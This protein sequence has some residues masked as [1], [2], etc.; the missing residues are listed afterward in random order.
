MILQAKSITDYI[1]TIN[2]Y[3]ELEEPEDGKKLKP[4]L[5]INETDS[6]KIQGVI[7][8]I[9]RFNNFPSLTH[10][11]RKKPHIRK[12]NLLA[13][14]R[15]YDNKCV[16]KCKISDLCD[17]LEMKNSGRIMVISRFCNEMH[18]DKIIFVHRWMEL[19]YKTH[20]TTAWGINHYILQWILNPK[21]GKLR[22]H[23]PAKRLE[24][25]RQYMIWA[26][27]KKKY[28][29]TQ[30]KNDFLNKVDWINEHLKRHIR[31]KSYHVSN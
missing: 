24:E 15:F 23:P 17:F 3:K 13:L 4:L 6:S 12:L 5:D 25:I 31:E 26:A 10:Q 20:I 29:T 7:D 2:K 21:N 1:R 14:F 16:F 22:R 19:H 27:L 11:F 28:K 18:R 30:K 9:D 8:Y